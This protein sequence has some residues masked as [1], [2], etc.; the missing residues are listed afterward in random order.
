MSGRGWAL[1]NAVLWMAAAAIAAWSFALPGG[2]FAAAAG[3]ALGLLAG[4]ALARSPLRG[5]TFALLGLLLAGAALLLQQLLT[6][7]PMPSNLL[8]PVLTYALAELLPSLLL[9]LALVGTLEGLARRH[10]AWRT[11]E[12]AVVGAVYAALFAGHRGG[13]INRPFF[14]VDPLLGGGHDPLPYF[15]L[16]GLGLAALLAVTLA[17]GS[18]G[19]RSFAGLLVLLAGLAALFFLLPQ[20]QLKAVAELHRSQGEDGKGGQGGKQKEPSK[21]GE[22]GE[23]EGAQGGGQGKKQDGPPDTFS[24]QSSGAA[25]FPVAVV[26]FHGDYTPAL[27]YYYF[28]ETAFSAYNG[29][30]VVQDPTLKYDRDAL[31]QFGNAPLHLQLPNSERLPGLAKP[32]FRELRT[33]VALMAAHAKPF[34]LVNAR[35]FRPAGNPDPRRFYAA[36]EV[37]SS[38]FLAPPA[39][40][41][42]EE[43]G[44]ADWDAAA[45]THYT[46]GPAD[47][48]YKQL[49]ERILAEL[50]EGL[51]AKPFARAVAIQLWLGENGTYS[52]HSN[53]GE[54][55]DPIGDFLFGD[56]TGHCVYF[57]HAACLLYRA[58]GLPARVSG[59]YAAQAN[60]RFGGASLLLRSQDAHAWPEVYLRDTGW[61]PLD[62]APA[63]V[64][65][66]PEQAPDQSL[67][68][69]LGSMAMQEKPPP[70]PPP[71]Q[72][73]T[74]KESIWRALKPFL[75]AALL[76][77]LALLL[78]LAY[79]IRLWRR[80]APAFASPREAPRLSYRAALDAASALG[81]RRGFGET[82]EAFAARLSPRSPAFAGL[83]A[84]H[85]RRALGPPAADP[86]PERC[87]AL[88]RQARRELRRSASAGRAFLAFLHPL[89][90]WRVH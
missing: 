9:P 23:D 66:E 67:Q 34:G 7:W 81:L 49:A 32:A 85:L 48:R 87:R 79:G 41:M 13:F 10:G 40:L 89:A 4:R 88:L 24:D 35:D 18:R 20:R 30:R 33:T 16:L 37:G 90:W 3:A 74:L 17:K 80:W 46:E 58:A 27:G 84:L 25:N 71:P 26:V 31:F 68:Q 62:I 59:G 54:S 8:G 42:N 1:L 15:L 50:P 60:F 82:R 72:Q 55:Q 6:R 76:I 86:Q 43:A 21:D 38:V 53:H 14:F 51:R 57:A 19:R 29:L 73:E 78:P 12:L 65:D 77:V 83:T 5:Y 64:L 2:V 56:R 45:W 52:L 69:M 11:L 28:R 61:M 44:A 47:P 63:K 22:N 75:E 70:P 39:A 36:Y